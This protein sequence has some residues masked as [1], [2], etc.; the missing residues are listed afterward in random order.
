MLLPAGD[1]CLQCITRLQD[2]L[3]AIKG[4]QEASVNNARDTLRISFDPDLVSFSRIESEAR[5]I[6]AD[7]AARIEHATVDLEGLDCPDCARSIARSLE[8]MPGVLW[9][10]VSFT[11]AQAHIEFERTHVD[12]A[13]ILHRIARHGVRPRLTGASSE[14]SRTS[15]EASRTSP[16][17][18]E[19]AR[20]AFL[21]GRSLTLAIATLLALG[22]VITDLLASS[23]HVAAVARALYAIA[24]LISGF[25]VFRAAL[26]ALRVQGVDMNVLMT[27][28]V[29]GAIAT[30][31]WGEACAVTLLY[32]IGNALQA[33]TLE[34][35]RRSLRD[36]MD[37]TPQ[38]ARVRRD[39]QEAALLVSEVQAG[40]TVIVRPGERIP[41]DG[42]VLQGR[43]VVN[44][45]PI[46]GESMPVDKEPGALV[47]AG[48]LNGPGL[49]EIRVTRVHRDTVL[50]RI[51]H[52]VEEAQA[53][54]SPYEQ[55]MDR[56]ARRY[57]P[58]VFLL[59]VLTALVPPALA[60]GDFWQHFPTWFHRGLS[61]L[62]IAC[63]CA[64]VISTPVAIVTALGVASRRGVLIKGGTYLEAIGEVRAIV[65]DKTGTL[66]QGNPK[67][68]DVLPFGDATC[69][70]VLS[71]A[72]ALLERSAHPLAIAIHQ[73]AQRY[74]GRRY[75][76]T[77]F[78][79]LPGLGVR[80]QVNGVPLYAGNVRLFI[81]HHIPL[82]RTV[83]ETL[84]TVEAH[85]KTV[86]LVGGPQ[87]ILGVILLSDAPRP[88]ARQV[89][90]ELRDLG[91]LHQA[92][93]SGDNPRV[94]AQ[95][96]H[97]TGIDA[98][99]GGLLPEQKVERV[100]A[101]QQR[102]GKVAMVGDGVNDAPALAASSVGIAMGAAGSDTALE[103]SDI[104][105]LRD[106][107]HAIPDLIRL[108]RCTLQI[109]RQ[110]IAFSLITKSLLL[111]AAVQITL[112]LWLAV[113]GDVGVALLVT[114]NAL[115]LLSNR[116]CSHAVHTAD[117][118]PAG[119]TTCPIP[120]TGSA[121][122]AHAD[123]NHDM[124]LCNLVFVHDRNA[125]EEPVP[126]YTYPEWEP[127]VVPFTGEAIRFG[128]RVPG[129]TLPI[130]IEDGGMSRLHGEFRMEG[131]RPV[132]IDLRSTNGIR[133]N[134]PSASALIPPETPIPLRFGDVFYVGRNT[135]IEIHPPDH[136]HVH[137]IPTAATAPCAVC[138]SHTAKTG[139]P[140]R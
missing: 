1:A 4:V 41:L 63:P 18:G 100:R 74:T 42:E 58:M 33:A 106:D 116:G 56:F 10:G 72:A 71:L 20:P 49:L 115:R 92:L 13:T 121:P 90:T 23:L 15:P 81:R 105:L 123:P 86:T 137:P 107:L 114:M 60:P 87:G 140:A 132:L 69:A 40:D 17:A 54:R 24:I 78:E 83:E 79:E 118:T 99:E 95:V 89:L 7:L 68:E 125:D 94:V 91:I 111:L 88:E 103:A 16:T 28:A 131:R 117:D 75:Q 133:H 21:K 19:P 9:V 73:E 55:L 2:G 37:L 61:L 62:L 34:R 51:A 65:Y 5:R 8:A 52:S 104:A 6:G 97:A 126:G 44:E 29:I 102:Y 96:A 14:A 113:A 39:G 80:G 129:S 138:A 3:T 57:T 11:A 27:L 22:G 84:A 110:N 70:E 128:R 108:S 135:R 32:G 76:V 109:I 122:H 77:D 36:L 119:A 38:R 43:S 136:S 98:S 93:L 59:A 12:L 47:Y 67:V 50:S 139:T 53:Q 101:L 134:S 82:P 30:D 46:T 112:P 35:T 64:L 25:N 31:Q 130:Q 127:R 48:T 66:T 26:L 124:A 45:A 120:A 85:G